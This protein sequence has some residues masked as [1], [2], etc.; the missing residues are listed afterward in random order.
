MN[1]LQ[2]WSST[3]DN[4][5][6]QGRSAAASGR[7]DLSQFWYMSRNNTQKRS[8]LSLKWMNLPQCSMYRDN[9]TTNRGGAS[10]PQRFA[11][12]WYVSRDNCTIHRGGVPLPQ[13][14][15]ICSSFNS[16]LRIIALYSKGYHYLTVVEF[17][18]IW[19]VSRHNWH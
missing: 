5:T 16:S 6:V 4:S 9:C 7:L 13:C 19:H 18:P 12:N 17:A 1:L 8:T 11:P 2:Y 10:L 14:G 3:E 15:I